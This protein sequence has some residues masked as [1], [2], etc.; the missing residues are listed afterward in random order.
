[1]LLLQLLFAIVAGSL[2]FGALWLSSSRAAA[3]NMRNW[4]EQW[5]STLDEISMPLYVAQ[6]DERHLQVEEYV[7]KFPEIAFVRFYSDSGELVFE[8]Y[9]QEGIAG[10]AP[11]TVAT[12]QGLINAPRDDQRYLLDTVEQD[13]PLMRIGK[14]IWTEALLMDGL[15]GL[16]LSDDSA[17][18]TTLIGFVEL[19]LNSS[20]YGEELARTIRS[21]T[22]WGTLLLVLLTVASWLV[23][24]RALL[25]LSHLQAPLKKLAKGHTDFTVETAG[26][27]EIVAIADALNTTVTALNE[28][29]KKLWHL[30]NHDSLTGLVNRHRFAEILNNELAR[31]EDTDNTSALLFIDLDQFKYV[32]DTVGHAAGDRLLQDVAERLTNG[33]RQ[34]D[35]VSRFGGDE[36]VVLLSDVNEKQVKDICEDLIRNASEHHFIENEES[37]TVRCSIGIT[38][39]WGNEFTPADLL[40]Q[41]DMAC[42]HAKSLGRNRYDF[43]KASSRSMAGMASEVGLSRQIQQALQDDTFVLHFQPIVDINTRQATHYEVLLRM[44][45]TNNKLILPDAF[46][47]AAI[48]FGL[49]IDVDRWVIR[50]A[51][52]QIAEMRAEH[53]D[54]GFTLNVSGNMFETPDFVDFVQKSLK[55]TGVPMEAI[56]LEITEQVAVRTIG[57][58]GRRITKLAKLGCKF[59]LDDFGAGYSSY[60]YLKTLP[61]D[62]IK[63]DGSFIRNIV[64]DIVDQKIVG[65][66]IEIAKATGKQTI[67]EHVVDYETFALLSELGVDFAQGHFLGKPGKVPSS[68][69]IPT[70]IADAKKKRRRKVS[71]TA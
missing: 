60:S 29:D 57:N 25:P 71:Q 51:L 33:V 24:R 69:E 36:F 49:M 70:S 66:I 10:L 63:I 65:S 41:A 39:I 27:T 23:Y 12:L 19:G 13:M 38:M 46:L 37:F 20:A 31:L 21:G 28:R 59:A 42:H 62:Y 54:I 67:A 14:P 56:V 43:Y 47:P 22:L 44:R 5:L 45:G 58:S 64:S 26:H 17:V 53:P 8:D 18:E 40:S 30:A 55:E 50:N 52:E 3:D 48:R 9:Q 35:T 34:S 7:Q 68:E 6:D 2:A 61:V 4:G 11:L 1:M 16:D 32:N 15:L